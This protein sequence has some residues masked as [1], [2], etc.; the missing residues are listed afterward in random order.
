MKIKGLSFVMVGEGHRKEIEKGQEVEVY[1]ME[2]L[3]LCTWSIHTWEVEASKGMK[4]I[5]IRNFLVT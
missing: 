4:E 2:L 1:G 3:I 5:A